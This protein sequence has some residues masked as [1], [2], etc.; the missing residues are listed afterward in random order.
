MKNSFSHLFDISSFSVKWKHMFWRILHSC[1]RKRIFCLVGT[2]IFYLEFCWN[3][4]NPGV[5]TFLRETL[6]LLVQIDFLTSGSCSF[7]CFLYTPAFSYFC[8]VETKKS[9]K[10]IFHSV[11]GRRIFFMVEIVFSYLISFPTSW[12]RYWN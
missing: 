2:V 11:W 4:S 5:E 7:V 6:F 8:Q 12:N 3:F 9:I 10:R 1:K